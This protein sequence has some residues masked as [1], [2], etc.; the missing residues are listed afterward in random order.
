[1]QNHKDIIVNYNAFD[2]LSALPQYDAPADHWADVSACTIDEC[3][4]V[5]NILNLDLPIISILYFRMGKSFRSFIHKDASVYPPPHILT[6]ALNLPLSNCSDVYMKWFNQ[7]S[8]DN[9]IS[10][11][12]GPSTGAK[13]PMLDYNDATCIDTMHCISS[14]LVRVD[15]WHSIENQSNDSCEYLISIRFASNVNP[16]MDLPMSK[17]LLEVGSNH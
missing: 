17:W 3:N 2:I 11:F 14:K 16:S 10:A 6:Y 1:M 5:S 7:S 15:G 13:T 9:V 8:P 4:K 12:P